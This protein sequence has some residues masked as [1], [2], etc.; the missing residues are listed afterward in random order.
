LRRRYGMRSRTRLAIVVV[1]LGAVGVGTYAAVAGDR[2]SKL[3]ADLVGYQE[4]PAVSTT[5]F[6]TFEGRVN[7]DRTELTYKVSYGGLE[8]NVT[9]SHIHFGQKGVAAGVAAFLC[10]NLG[11]GPTGT[12]PCPPSPAT[13]TGT[14]TATDVIGPAGQGITAGEWDELM[15]AIENGVAYVNVHSTKWPGGE[16]RAQLNARGEQNGD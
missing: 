4:V 2:F 5:G 15:A 1:V 14:L 16:V 8:G 6:G 9:Q 3:K 12:Q 11:N 7:R 10:S 13:V